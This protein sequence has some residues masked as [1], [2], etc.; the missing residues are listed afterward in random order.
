[1]RRTT[2]SANSNDARKSHEQ[3]AQGIQIEVREHNAAVDKMEADFGLV[4][5]RG[6][7]DDRLGQVVSPKL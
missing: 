4:A 1:V 2:S 6:T 7:V 3:A 5:Y